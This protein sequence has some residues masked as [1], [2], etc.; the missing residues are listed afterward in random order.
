MDEPPGEA[1]SHND[2]PFRPA[3]FRTRFDDPVADAL[4]GSVMVIPVAVLGQ[5][6][7]KR[8]FAKEPEV[9]GAFLLDAA[10]H[11]LGV[12]IHVRHEAWTCTDHTGSS[13]A[14]V[15]SI[16]GHIDTIQRVHVHGSL[17]AYDALGRRLAKTVNGRTTRFWH[18]GAQVIQE[19]ELAA[20]PSQAAITGSE[21][22]G[23]AAN[24]ALTPATGGVLAGAGITRVH[25]Q[26]VTTVVPVGFLG[27]KGKVY[28]VRTNGKTYGWTV[29]QTGRQQ[30]RNY[31]IAAELDTSA[32]LKPLAGDTA[33]VWEL[34]LPN[35]T[36]PV[37]V[38]CGDPL[39]TLSSNHLRIEGT[40]VTDPD[41]S[42]A[43]SY[44][45][46]DFDGYAVTATVSDGKLTITSG[47]GALDPKLCFIEVGPAGGTIDAAALARLTD[48]VERGTNATYEAIQPYAA[49]AYVFG[50]YVDE[51]LSY[52]NN[53]TR[54]FTHSNHLYSPSAVTNAAGQ[55]QE[56]Y[57]YDAYGKMTVTDAAGGLRVASQHGFVLGFQCRSIDYETGN[58]Y[59]RTRYYSFANG[60]F[61]NRMPWSVVSGHVLSNYDRWVWRF[62]G[63][64]PVMP[65]RL[66]T[67]GSYHQGRY[68]LYDFAQGAPSRFLESFSSTSDASGN[69]YSW[70][71]DDPWGHGLDD[72][73]DPLLPQPGE[74]AEIWN[75]G[76]I[77]EPN[78]TC[79]GI[80][81]N[82]KADAEAQG[83]KVLG[84]YITPDCPCD[85]FAIE[86]YIRP[87]SGY[88]FKREEVDGWSEKRGV[89]APGR[90]TPDAY[91]KFYWIDVHCGFLCIPEGGLM[92]GQEFQRHKADR[93]FPR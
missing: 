49:R 17:H 92:T 40:A 72:N 81:A 58:A 55:V 84:P 73:G 53:G 8:S 30:L 70:A 41:P 29:A 34:A 9:V 75:D 64:Q 35:G 78:E 80:F 57:R 69:C 18:A 28:S 65:I 19:S 10:E 27:D 51:V 13:V 77:P 32:R 82:I 20:V 46:G 48:L 67:L 11:A 12:G 6:S 79:Q 83:K 37:V 47:T 39:S 56:R 23:T 21:A 71:V 88:H 16:S 68:N 44:T 66:S 54:Y 14:L 90:T 3:D 87:V 15:V 74:Y 45:Q 85:Y 1:R 93:R 86:L 2:R 22:D 60:R 25:F 50:G 36:Y 63:H 38:V 59:F 7:A 31:Q 62:R 5:R 4:M 52:T 91:G 33:G 42:I 26:P 24:G 43:P 89:L 61:L 76:Y